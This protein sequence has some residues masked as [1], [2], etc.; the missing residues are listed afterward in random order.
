[1]NASAQSSGADSAS[2]SREQHRFPDVLST[3]Q[4]HQNPFNTKSPSS[5]R[6]DTVTEASDIELKLFRIQVHA[7]QVLNQDVHAVLSLTT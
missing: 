3:S 5:L 6:R 7:L 4:L 1:M 2:V